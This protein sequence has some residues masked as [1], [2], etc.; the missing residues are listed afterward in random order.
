MI[1]ISKLTRDDIGRWV[2]FKGFSGKE[3]IG[4]LKFWNDRYI[5]VVFH[6]DDNWGNYADYTGESVNSCNLEFYDEKTEEEECEG[7]PDALNPF[8]V[9]I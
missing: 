5:F 1:D 3:E 4:K 2:K 9:G 6:C 8:E 7:N